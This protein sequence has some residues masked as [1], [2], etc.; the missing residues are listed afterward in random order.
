[1]TNFVITRHQGAINWLKQQG[2]RC[3]H[4]IIHL[5]SEHISGFKKG[6]KVIGT[7]P[8]AIAYE[9]CQQGAEY[10]HLSI[11]STF[12]DRIKKELSAADMTKSKT[13]LERFEISNPIDFSTPKTDNPVLNAAFWFNWENQC[14]KN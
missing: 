1:M 11:Q 6:D 2:V 4:H 9:V 3:D 8:V 7:L 5:T 12:Q 14:K 13:T 10:W